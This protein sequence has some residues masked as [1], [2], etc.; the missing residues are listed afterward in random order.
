M[1]ETHLF[2][3]TE[4]TWCAE[5]VTSR[6]ERGQGQWDAKSNRKWQP[7][8]KLLRELWPRRS[9]SWWKPPRSSLSQLSQLSF[10]DRPGTKGCTT[11]KISKAT[12]RFEFRG[13]TRLHS[14]Q[15][16]QS[17]CTQPTTGTKSI[18]TCSQMSRGAMAKLGYRLPMW[19]GMNALSTTEYYCEYAEITR[20]NHF[21]YLDH[22]DH[23]G[24]F[25]LEGSALQPWQDALSRVLQKSMQVWFSSKE[26]MQKNVKQYIVYQTWTHRQRTLWTSASHKLCTYMCIISRHSGTCQVLR[27]HMHSLQLILPLS[28]VKFRKLCLPWLKTCR[29]DPVACGIK[30][31]I[32]GTVW[33]YN[34]FKDVKL[35]RKLMDSR[36]KSAEISSVLNQRSTEW[37]S[38]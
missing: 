22:F 4:A 3:I 24:A 7:N 10:Q 9:S 15:E 14:Q 26:K 36:A 37:H 6:G 13:Y 19:K 8:Q 12:K 30:G 31:N 35:L 32:K 17:S 38:E 34:A 27:N 21:D 20:F 5:E 25:V 18:H 23:F 29:H 16:A 11:S 33:C 1:Q 2:L 28:G